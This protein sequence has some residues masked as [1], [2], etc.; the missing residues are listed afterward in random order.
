[1]RASHIEPWRRL[2]GLS[3]RSPACYPGWGFAGPLVQQTWRWPMIIFGSGG[4]VVHL[5]PVGTQPCPNCERERHFS[6]V[7]QYSYEHVWFVFA[8]VSK[9]QYLYLC[10]TCNRG[11]ELESAE[12]EKQ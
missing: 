11:W 5:G 3:S 9:K 6:L 4:D 2:A 8:Y 10:D 1:S 12:V 7:L